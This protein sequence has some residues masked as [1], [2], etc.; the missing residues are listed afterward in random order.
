MTGALRD[1]PIEV[2]CAC[3]PK[4][5]ETRNIRR[6]QDGKIR[7]QVCALFRRKEMNM[8]NKRQAELWQKYRLTLTGYDILLQ[9]QNSV[10]AICKLPDY[11]GRLSVDHNHQTGKVRGLL[12]NNCN[13]CLGMLHDDI[14]VLMNAVEYLQKANNAGA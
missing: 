7:C 3:C 8:L 9:K 13:R 1:T 11:T 12:C 10:C 4:K 14:T 2:Q 5:F 6:G